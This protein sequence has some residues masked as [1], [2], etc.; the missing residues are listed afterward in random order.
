MNISAYTL[1]VLADSDKFAMPAD[2]SAELSEYP[3]YGQD[4]VYIIKKR[5]LILALWNL[6]PEEKQ[7]E[8]THSYFEIPV[9]SQAKKDSP[10]LLWEK[11]IPLQ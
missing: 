9:Y 10:D 6:L 1:P 7:P 2:F 4:A 11:N 3:C 5:A 8:N